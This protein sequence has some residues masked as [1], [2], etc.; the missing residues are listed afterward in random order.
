M[1]LETIMLRIA[2]LCGIFSLIFSWPEASHAETLYRVV[3]RD[4]HTVDAEANERYLVHDKKY[5]VDRSPLLTDT[6]RSLLSSHDLKDLMAKE[7]ENRARNRALDRRRLNKENE[8]ARNEKESQRIKTLATPLGRAL[9]NGTRRISSELTRYPQLF[10]VITSNRSG[11]IIKTLE[12][13]KSGLVDPNT[14]QKM[15][16]LTGATHE[17]FTTVSDYRVDNNK[18]SG[19][20]IETNNRIHSLSLNMELNKL[21]SS[22]TVFSTSLS[23]S[24]TELVTQASSR[25]NSTVPESLLNGGIRKAIKEMAEALT[26]KQVQHPVRQGLVINIAPTDAQGK[27]VN[28]DIE[29]DGEWA[30]NTPSKLEVPEGRHTL[31]LQVGKAVWKKKITF[32]D[33][34]SITPTMQ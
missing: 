18:F 1:H 31:Q 32:R 10:S 19:Y 6:E 11:E 3:I 33:G 7:I 26:P 15:G 22:E 25:T 30:G 5:S 28:A 8:R 12:Y 34:M 9:V 21:E 2:V 20:G 17:L 4:V 27:P 29:I 23:V 14:A 24:E 16:K 13:Q